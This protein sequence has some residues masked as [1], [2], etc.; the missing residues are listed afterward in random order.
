MPLE[1]SHMTG[2]NILIVDDEFDLALMMKTYFLRKGNNVFVSHTI[3]DGLARAGSECLDVVILSND[4][5][6]DRERVV[7]QIIEAIP[8]VQLMTCGKEVFYRNEARR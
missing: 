8:D 6:A 5:Q 4:Y 1:L 7:K 2:C 3:H